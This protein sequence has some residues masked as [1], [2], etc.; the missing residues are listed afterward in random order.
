MRVQP[1]SVP[2]QTVRQQDFV[3]E[4]FP[5]GVHR[6]NAYV[7]YSDRDRS[8]VLIDPGSDAAVLLARV[9]EL[10]LSIEAVLLTHAHWD[11]VGALSA[12]AASCG[13]RVFLHAADR[14]LLKAAP[15]YAFRV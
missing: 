15:F 9:S 8:G 14:P 1:Q 6:A 2:A 5:V 4:R 13:A 7:V 11:H 10:G 3:I 12:V